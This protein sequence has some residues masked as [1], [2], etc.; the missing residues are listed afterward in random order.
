MSDDRDL[1]FK[2]ATELGKLIRDKQVSSVELTR[3]Y[4]DALDTRGRKLNAV[5]ELARE[6]SLSQARQADEELAAGKA[7]SVLHGVPWGAKDLLATK[8][9]PTRWGSPAH[10]DQKFDHDAT[11]VER[12]RNHGCVLLAKLSMIELA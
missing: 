3:M 11:V 10:A 2:S 7:R 5:A 8:D 12:L 1:R 9:L 4:L 6:T